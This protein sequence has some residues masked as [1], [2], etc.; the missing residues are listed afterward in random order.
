MTIRSLK[1]GSI[2]SLAGGNTSAAVPDTPIVGTATPAGGVAEVSVA[3]TE[4]GIGSAAT[5]FTV[6]STPDSVTA[7]GATS[8]INVTGLTGN[9]SYSFQVRGVNANGN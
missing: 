9:T 2:T 6:I 5:S 1:N 4:T 3:F 7:S 8:P